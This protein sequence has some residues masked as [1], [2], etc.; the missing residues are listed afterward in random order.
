[1]KQGA[2]AE[3]CAQGD[4]RDDEFIKKGLIKMARSECI[5]RGKHRKTCNSSAFIEKKKIRK[6]GGGEKHEGRNT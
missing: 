2:E 4:G 1:M 3:T 5:R 6:K